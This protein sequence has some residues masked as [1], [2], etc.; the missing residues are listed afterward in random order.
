MPEYNSI[1]LPWAD[2]RKSGCR[3]L[4]EKT[5]ALLPNIS[6]CLYYI[7]EITGLTK[8][9]VPTYT[10]CFQMTDPICNRCISAITMNYTRT[11]R[12]GRAPDNPKRRLHH[13][14]DGTPAQ[15]LGPSLWNPPV[16]WL[17]GAHWAS[18][19][20]FD[21]CKPPWTCFSVITTFSLPFVT[22]YLVICKT[23]IF[24]KVTLVR[25]TALTSNDICSRGK[26]YIRSQRIVQ[27]RCTTHLQ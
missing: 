27:D 25:I 7:E 8:I 15:K 12:K 18:A 21:L 17:S 10:G 19:S 20:G 4:L 23:V 24:L 9:L 13:M 6:L 5:I 16:F 11:T 26:T 3:E 1:L 22:L 2:T 14:W